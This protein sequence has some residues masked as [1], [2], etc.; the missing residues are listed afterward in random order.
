LLHGAGERGTDN[1]KQLVH[2]AYEL[3]DYAK[4]VP[5]YAIF[6]QCPSGDN[7]KWAN[8]DWSKHGHSLNQETD[9]VRMVFEIIDE[10]EKT[11]KIEGMMCPKC[12]AHVK[13]ALEK[14]EGVTA[15]TVSLEKKNAVVSGS[16]DAEALKNAVIEEGYEVLSVE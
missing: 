7:K 10:M 15:V 5:F 16:A 2:G 3:M 14:V 6:P 11:L 13:N 8:L 12:V 9:L 4:T 1:S